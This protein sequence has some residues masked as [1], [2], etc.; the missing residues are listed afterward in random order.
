RRG[1]P[2]LRH[3]RAR[4]HA[5]VPLE[6]RADRPVGGVVVD[7]EH[8]PSLTVG[9]GIQR[10]EQSKGWLAG[11]VRDDDERELRGH[12]RTLAG[13]LM[14]GCDARPSGPSYLSSPSS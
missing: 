7:D 8:V 10:I 4:A 6:D 13:T 1:E 11:V 5:G 3:V 14:N 9:I 12:C 2:E